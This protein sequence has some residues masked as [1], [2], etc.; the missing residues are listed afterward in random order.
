MGF[1]KCMEYNKYASQNAVSR[2]IVFKKPFGVKKKGRAA[3][4]TA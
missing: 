3:R 2:P 1:I 4:E